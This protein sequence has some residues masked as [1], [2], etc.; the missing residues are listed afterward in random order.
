M[1]ISADQPVEISAQQ[2]EQSKKVYKPQGNV[3]N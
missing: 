3:E 1:V 2:C